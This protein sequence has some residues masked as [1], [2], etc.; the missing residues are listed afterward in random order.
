MK[1]TKIDFLYLNEEDMIKA[2]VK[3][4]AGCV[5]AMEEMFKLLKI[6]DYRMGGP[7]G[8]SHGVM[9]VFPE[10]PIFPNMPK[11]GPD[12]RFMAMPAYLGGKFDMAGMKWY[13]SNVENRTKGLPRSILML[14]LNDKDTGAPI[15]YMSANILSAYRTGAVPGVGVKYFAKEDSKVVGIIGPGVMSKTAFAATMAVR[16]GIETVKI[17]GRSKKSIDGFI[18]YLNEEYPQI[19][20]IIVVDTIEDAVRDCDIV[21]IATSS[22]TGDINEYPYISEEWIKP[23]AILCCPAAARFDDDFILNRARTVT[24]NIQLYEAWAE[25]MDFPAYNSIPIPAVHCMDLIAEG[26]MSKDKIDDLGDVLTGKIPAHRK[27]DEIVIY[28]VGGMPIEDVAWGTIVYRSAI[29][30]GIGTKLNLW[31]EPQLA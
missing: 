1:D 30:K 14:T 7:N 10:E 21:H 19:K 24:D 31:D 13:G 11:D 20:D 6:G 27:E 18:Q 22:P 23:G 16:S 3:E 26:K 25:E 9:M 17:K 4:M 15:A 8:N 2:G 28:S 5:E 12:R 29:E